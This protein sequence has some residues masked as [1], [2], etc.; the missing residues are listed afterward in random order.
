MLLAAA[1]AP[2]A[3]PA[4]LAQ[5]SSISGSGHD[6]SINGPGPVKA[7]TNTEVCIFCHVAHGAKPSVPLWNHALSASDY[8]L[9]TSSTYVQTN[10]QILSQRSKLCLSC[11][12][13][14]VAARPDG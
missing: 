10:P 9:Y 6:L 7:T 5:S 4:L 14:T 11:H 3:V 8:P 1:L 13:G 12:D 2:L